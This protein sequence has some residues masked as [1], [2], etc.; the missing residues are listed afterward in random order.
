MPF[1]VCKILFKLVQVS[2][3]CLGGSLFCG[4]SVVSPFN[5]VCVTSVPCKILVCVIMCDS[6]TTA[7]VRTWHHDHYWLLIRDLSMEQLFLWETAA[8]LLW[9]H[10]HFSFTKFVLFKR[11]VH[12]W[13]TL[14]PETGDFV[15]E[16]G[17]FVSGNRWLPLYPETGDFVAVFGNKVACFRIQSCRFWQWRR[18]KRFLHRVP[19]KTKP[20]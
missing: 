14:Y 17:S 20:L 7:P 11:P 10:S 6:F 13:A 16:N 8:L 19:E 1:H 9:V 15:A 2:G 12:T 4:H 5:V 3:K 18:L